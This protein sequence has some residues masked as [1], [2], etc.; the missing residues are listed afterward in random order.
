MFS[1]QPFIDFS[2]E[3]CP[4]LIGIQ[5]LCQEEK[6]ELFSTK[7]QFQSLL[8]G[9]TLT[10]TQEKS[11]RA[12]LL[13][14]LTIF[15][16]ECDDNELALVSLKAFIITY[17]GCFIKRQ[18]TYFVLVIGFYHQDWSLLGCDS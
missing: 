2:T 3:Q 13:D 14:E 11:T 18:F 5:R 10:R 9:D 7:Y 1:T 15:K 16:K 6:D 17:F 12:V 4:M 8:K